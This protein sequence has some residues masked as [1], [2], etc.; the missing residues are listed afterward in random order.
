MMHIKADGS[1]PVKV[2][3]KDGK[4]FS[5]KELQGYV[6]GLVEIVRLPSGMIMA[7]NEEGKLI[8]LPENVVATG[9]WKKEYPISKYP[10]DNDELV[11][12]D[13]LLGDEGDFAE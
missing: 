5:P 11:V 3:P 6:G 10:D 9:I 8:G 1:E 7:M 4:I 2:F 12:G 13:V